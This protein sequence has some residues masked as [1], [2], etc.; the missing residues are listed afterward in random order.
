VAKKLVEVP[1]I[2]VEKRVELPAK[3]S[4]LV[5]V[6][7]QNDFVKPGGKLRV[8]Q[9]EATIPKIK[10]LLD[11]ARRAGAFRIF[12]K[13]THFAWDWELQIWGEHAVKGTWGWEVV[14]ELKPEEEELVVE[15]TK[16]DAF[17]GTWLDDAL[18]ALGV[19]NLVVV[20]T[21]A[22]ICV[23]HTAASAALRGYKV[24]VPADAV[25]ALTEFDLVLALRQVAFL[26]KG[27]VVESSEG[28][29]FT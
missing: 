20:G 8:P 11:R 19:K 7:M 26:Y 9:A 21:V 23:L 15:K 18:R 5:I 25:S 29:E 28:V 1:E 16:Y 12:T 6:D 24:V 14:D 13:D 2:P 10:L 4:A 22:N 27:V 17:Y 3:Q